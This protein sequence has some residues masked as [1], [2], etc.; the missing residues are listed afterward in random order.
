VGKRTTPNRPI[1]FYRPPI[2]GAEKAA[3]AAVLGRGWLT[4]GPEAAR[5]E[6]E[7]RE[8]LGVRHAL[9]VSSGTAAIH[10][11]LL[12]A[13]VGSGDEVITSPYTFVATAEVIAHCGATPV[14]VDVEPGGYGIDPNR[15]EEKITARTRAILPIGVGGLPCRSDAIKKIARRHKLAVIEDGAH[16]LGAGYKNKPIGRWADATAFSFYSTKNLTTGEGGMVVTDRTPWFKRMRI[17]SRHGISKATWD[18]YGSRSWMYD[19]TDQGYKYNM[20]DI[21]A[22]IGRTQL[23]RFPQMQKKRAAITQWYRDFADDIEGIAFPDP[24]PQGQSAHHLMMVR[25]TDPKLIKKRDFILAELTRRDI[26]VSVHFIPLHLMTHF[27]RNYGTKPGD[28]PEAEAGY[29][30]TISLPLFPDLTKSQV[31]HVVDTLRHV[32]HG[33]G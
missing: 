18:R 17:L 11:G 1:D 20:P 30:A 25:L 12:A 14:F 9:A 7:F 15:I 26:G 21:P 10:L 4:S 19:V 23:R 29:R 28:Y 32:I 16:T 2:G 22:A 6:E 31:R 8:F 27:R 33:R 3:V 24:P 5:F 13:G